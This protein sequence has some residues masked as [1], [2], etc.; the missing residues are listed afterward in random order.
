MKEQTSI[1]I[2]FSNCNKKLKEIYPDY[3]LRIAQVIMDNNNENNLIDQTEYSVYNKFGDKIDLTICKD[4]NI[5]IEY[6]V[7]NNSLLNIDKILY[8]K[9]KG[10]DIL[11]I[12]DNFF[13]DICFPYSDENSNSDMILTDRVSDIYQNYSICEVGCEYESLNIE[14]MKVICNCKVKEKMSPIIKEGNFKTYIA[15]SFLNSNFGVIKCY[16]LV[17]GIKG[18]KNNI[19]FWLFGVMILFHF[20]L[21]IMYFIRGIT[22]IKNYINNEMDNNGYKSNGC[23][24][25]SLGCE[26]ETMEIMSNEDIKTISYKRKKSKFYQKSKMITSSNENIN[27]E[28]KKNRFKNRKSKLYKIN[29]ETSNNAPPKKKE[30]L[31]LYSKNT[32]NNDK[33]PNKNNINQSAIITSEDIKNNSLE[34]KIIILIKR[35]KKRREELQNYF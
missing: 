29:K 31:F 18:K 3:Q 20:P 9:N 33:F 5:K 13:N 1:N 7:K 30:N 10:I 27:E 21:Y 26:R 14:N 25:N 2:D 28:N 22:P 12:K 17:F 11:Q 23:Y 35:V 19:G 24:N 8:F 6:S 32:D 4:T 34:L 16:K 15:S